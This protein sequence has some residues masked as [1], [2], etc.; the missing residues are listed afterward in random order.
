M[1]AIGFDHLDPMYR[2]AALCL[3]GLFTVLTGFSLRSLWSILSNGPIPKPKSFL[4][5]WFLPIGMTTVAT[6]LGW[7]AFIV[8]EPIVHFAFF[9]YSVCI[10]ALVVIFNVVE[11][12][13]YGFKKTLKMFLHL[14]LL[15]LG[16]K[17]VIHNLDQKLNKF[18]ID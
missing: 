8:D 6:V 3:A 12:K 7:E 15:L 5:E 13:R 4:L 16:V 1:S 11:A 17:K 18:P 2:V 9:V 14:L 10:F